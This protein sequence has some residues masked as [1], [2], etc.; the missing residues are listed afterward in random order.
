[1]LEFQAN[2]NTFRNFII[3]KNLRKLRYVK[4]ATI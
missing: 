3:C 1:M 2:K 4:N